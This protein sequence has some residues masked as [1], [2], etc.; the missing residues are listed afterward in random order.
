MATKRASPS[1]RALT[2]G[3]GQKLWLAL[4]AS[5]KTTFFKGKKAEFT[6]MS[7]VFGLAAV[8]QS[9]KVKCYLAFDSP[10]Q[11]AGGQLHERSIEQCLWEKC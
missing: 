2:V 8:A 10:C 6:R 5:K 1:F 9:F 7:C 3:R 4:L 11:C